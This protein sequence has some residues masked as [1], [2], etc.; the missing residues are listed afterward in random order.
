MTL[1]TN[2]KHNTGIMV[3]MIRKFAFI[4]LFFDLILL[5]YAL[6][7]ESYIWLLNTQVA[8]VSALF[9]T[10]ASFF[11]YK[12]NISKR[13]SSLDLSSSKSTKEN[14][15]KIDEIED[16]YDLYAQDE[17]TIVQEE[18]NATQIKE[19]LKEEKA[20][21]KNNYFKNTIFSAGGFLSIYRIFGYVLLV[22][23]FFALNNNG[24][25]QIIPFMIGISILPFSTLCS[26]L[27]FKY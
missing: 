20:K 10:I 18:L 6:V 15:D 7:F 21:L 11:S 19:I 23:G 2:I 16:P 3:K 22:F 13:L 26:K 12:K 9:I 25:F 8:F 14:P 17:E 1:D 24:I 5:S 27:F 4:F